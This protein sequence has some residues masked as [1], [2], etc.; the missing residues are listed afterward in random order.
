MQ[1]GLGSEALPIFRRLRGN[2]DSLQDAPNWA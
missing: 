1:I 2:E